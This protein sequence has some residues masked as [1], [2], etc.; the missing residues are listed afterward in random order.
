M[1]LLMTN[2][3]TIIKNVLFPARKQ[4]I[5][6]SGSIITADSS[7]SDFPRE[8]RFPFFS[9][10]EKLSLSYLAC[11]PFFFLKYLPH[12]ICVSIYL[13]SVGR[14]LRSRDPEKRQFID[15]HR[16][17]NKSEIT[18]RRKKNAD[19]SAEARRHC[20]RWNA[21]AR[22]RQKEGDATGKT[23]NCVFFDAHSCGWH[24]HDANLRF[25]RA[26]R[27]LNQLSGN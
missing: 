7:R 26:R 27:A 8:S 18:Q 11:K 3:L 25:T 24:M 14:I 16:F 12:N 2:L 15:G 22:R 10:K 9:T 4:R 17:R 21:Q 13:L 23:A 20:Q 5:A 19:F 6:L 1:A